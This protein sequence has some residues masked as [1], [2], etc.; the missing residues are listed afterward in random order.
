MK[1]TNHIDTFRTHLL[2]QIQA[3][4]T[5]APEALERELS[6]A[7]GISELAQVAVNS[8]KVEVDFLRASGQQHAPFLAPVGTQENPPALPAGAPPAPA[9]SSTT[10]RAPASPWPIGPMPTRLPGLQDGIVSVRRHIM[11]DED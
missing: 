8:A 7:K 11:Q 10:P 6:R 1:Q 2:D 9:A 3:L 5:A 4:R